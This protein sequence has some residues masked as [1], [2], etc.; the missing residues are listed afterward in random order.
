MSRFIVYRRGEKKHR[1]RIG[2]YAPNGDGEKTFTLEQ[3]RKK[4]E[5]Y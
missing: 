5:A 2:A 4:A 1:A 3:A